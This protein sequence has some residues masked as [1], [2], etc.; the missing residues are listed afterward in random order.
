MYPGATLNAFMARGKPKGHGIN[1][2]PQSTDRLLAITNALPD[3]TVETAAQ[4]ILRERALDTTIEG[5]AWKDILPDI[6]PGIRDL[7][8]NIVRFDSRR[9]TA[10]EALLHNFM[11]E[12]TG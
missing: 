3:E 4:A 5:K 6:D 12:Q 9:M 10:E 11:T 7:V 1:I 2:K 8:A